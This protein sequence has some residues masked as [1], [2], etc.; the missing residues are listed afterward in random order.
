MSPPH[1][2]KRF[3]IAHGSMDIG[4][5]SCLGL[6]PTTAC[7]EFH[8]SCRIGRELLILP[9][10]IYNVIISLNTAKGL[11]SVPTDMCILKTSSA[12]LLLMKFATWLLQYFCGPLL[13]LQPC[14]LHFRFF[15]QTNIVHPEAVSIPSQLPS[16]NSIKRLV[17]CLQFAPNGGV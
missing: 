15:R 13:F 9:T 8:V 12:I 14:C 6:Y 2:C 16:L 7:P 11:L 3:L 4:D 10:Y 1:C 17:F 5:S